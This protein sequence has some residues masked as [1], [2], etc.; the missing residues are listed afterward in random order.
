MADE[1]WRVTG[2]LLEQPTMHRFA[3]VARNPVRCEA[4]GVEFDTGDKIVCYEGFKYDPV[5][6]QKQFVAADLKKLALW[7]SSSGRIC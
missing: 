6:M 2:E 4:L 3:V 1:D 7:P 5:A